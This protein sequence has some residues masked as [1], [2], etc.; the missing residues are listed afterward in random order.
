MNYLRLRKKVLRAHQF[1]RAAISGWAYRIRWGLPWMKSGQILIL[2]I[3]TGWNKPKLS[4]GPYRAR[5][6]RG[7]RQCPYYDWELKVCGN[8]EEPIIGPTGQEFPNG[9]RCWL[10]AKAQTPTAVCFMEDIG[11]ESR[12]PT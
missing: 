9:C 11:M 12:W 8:S 3:L 1:T 4:F 7:C 5:L 2:S 10:P 6:Q